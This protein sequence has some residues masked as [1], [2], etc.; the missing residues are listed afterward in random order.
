MSQKERKSQQ[1]SSDDA[2]T[3]KQF[4]QYF[5]PISGQM[6]WKVVSEATAIEDDE[7][8]INQ[9][10]R[11]SSGLKHHIKKLK[12]AGTNVHVADIGTGT[13]LLSLMAVRHGAD[14]VTAVEVFKPMAITAEKV[15]KKNGYDDKIKVIHLRSTEIQENLVQEKA[16]IIV[17]EVFD[18]ELIGE[19]ALR[20]FKEG[21][22]TLGKKGCRVV[23]AK[24]RV[25][26]CPISSEKLQQF[27]KLPN[28]RFKAP[29]SDC[30][31]T[32][33]VF[34][35]QLSEIDLNWFEVLAEPFIAFKF[36]YVF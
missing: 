7:D 16:D 12:S 17:A 1:N 3:P 36:V 14:K 35:I 21:L 24:G 33:A 5:N 22:M 19:G 28:K 30:T 13:S 2:T 18:T 31:G 27:W 15:I 23:P 20:S 34:D 4:Y 29:F 6:G 32:A 11:Y 10:A 25:W 8:M 26:I 9:I